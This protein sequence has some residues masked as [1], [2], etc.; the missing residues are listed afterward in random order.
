MGKVRKGDRQVLK[1]FN[2]QI[3]SWCLPPLSVTKQCE[4]RE[5]VNRNGK[6][7]GFFA[8]GL[9][10]RG[11]IMSAPA[12][13]KIIACLAKQ[14]GRFRLRN[15][16]APVQLPSLPTLEDGSRGGWIPCP[17]RSAA[18]IGPAAL[19]MNILHPWGSQQDVQMAGVVVGQS[20]SDGCC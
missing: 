9:C 13:W 15:R 17:L 12:A 3:S 7:L 6:D 2:L 4:S 20:N 1:R 18:G 10:R 16:K 14:G 5:P 8:E 11:W 19:E